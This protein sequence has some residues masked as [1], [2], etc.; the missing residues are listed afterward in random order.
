MLSRSYDM[1]AKK[2]RAVTLRW[3]VKARLDWRYRIVEGRLPFQ[4]SSR[5]RVSISLGFVEVNPIRRMSIFKLRRLTRLYFYKT[6][7]QAKLNECLDFL[8]F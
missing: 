8:A 1:R 2:T 4:H 6:K 7:Y 5:K 3:Q